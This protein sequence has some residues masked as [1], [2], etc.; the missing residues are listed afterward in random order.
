MPSWVLLFFWH[1]IC[2]CLL[3]IGCFTHRNGM[4][5]ALGGMVS[6]MAESF[7]IAR[8]RMSTSVDQSAQMMDHLSNIMEDFLTMSIKI[9]K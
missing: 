4:S 5:E 1:Y 3:P 2:D 6:T 7:S 8:K 9:G